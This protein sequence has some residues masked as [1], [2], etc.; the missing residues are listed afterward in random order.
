[1][2]GSEPVR[3]LTS[4]VSGDFFHVLGAKP[5]VGRTFLTE[6]SKPGGTPV[7]V[8]SYGFWQRLLGEKSDLAGTKLRLMDQNV[9][10]VGVMPAG[11]AF[12]QDA[13]VWIPRELFPQETSRSAHNCSKNSKSTFSNK[14]DVEDR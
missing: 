1:M 9:I 8:V 6:E 12:P 10:V 14:S 2:G 3:A 5:V 4:A 11:F 7:A 13:E